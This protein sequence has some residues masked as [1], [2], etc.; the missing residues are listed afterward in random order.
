METMFSLSQVLS[1]KSLPKSKTIWSFPFLLI[2]SYDN[3]Q[4]RAV[5]S[6]A[7][8]ILKSI[9]MG[10]NVVIF[11]LNTDRGQQPTE[12][13]NEC[14]ILLQ[15]LDSG[16]H[17]DISDR[18]NIKLGDKYKAQ[19]RFVEAKQLFK[20]ALTIVKT[21]GQKREEA[22]VHGR[23]GNVC[24]KLSKYQKAK[25]YHEKALAI[26][27][28]I[29]DRRYQ[30]YQFSFSPKVIVDY[31][32]LTFFLVKK[33]EEDFL[34]GGRGVSVEFCFTCNA[35]RV[36][37]DLDD[38]LCLLDEDLSSIQLCALH[39]EMRNTEQLLASIEPTEMQI[40]QNIEDIV[41]HALLTSAKTTI[42]LASSSLSP[43]AILTST[44]LFKCSL[45]CRFFLRLQYTFPRLK[46]AEPCPILSPISIAMAS[47]FS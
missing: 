35:V 3:K 14:V 45:A 28:E 13:C 40:L 33:D 41:H 25:E 23:L 20:C 29:G 17:L 6:D 42:A 34:L 7:A 2:L 12:L 8:E 21:I 44:A 32:T 5:M 38:L 37:W 46:Y 27:I 11:L 4:E 30:G 31:K 16:S 22:L 24:A 15:N 9:K 1:N 26:G 39:L 36:K 43:T 19:S 18:L 47:A 10:I